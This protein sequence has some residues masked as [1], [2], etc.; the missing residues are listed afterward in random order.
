MSLQVCDNHQITFDSTFENGYE[1]PMCKMENEIKEK[2][3]NIEEL[4]SEKRD[5]ERDIERL[6]K[7]VEG[8]KNE[9]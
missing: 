5:L 3:E 2:D 7:E 8:L 4:E 9:S 6:E 1:C